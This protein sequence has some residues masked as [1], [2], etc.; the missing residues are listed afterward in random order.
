MVAPP[1]IH[2]VFHLI[3]AL[4]QFPFD[5]SLLI[6]LLASR[7]L[8][9]GDRKVREATWTGPQP[10][11]QP[12]HPGAADVGRNSRPQAQA[13]NKKVIFFF[14]KIT[15]TYL[16]TRKYAPRGRPP[17]WLAGWP[18]EDVTF[19]FCFCFSLLN[20]SCRKNSTRFR[21][22]SRPPSTF[23]NV[24]NVKYISLVFSGRKR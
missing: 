18:P 1:E 7:Q 12:V 5:N 4:S 23:R 8:R 3:A 24:L 15:C 19:C 21:V 20:F 2:E 22:I 10:S 14:K 13:I 16:D 11:Q 17:G 6:L 9:A